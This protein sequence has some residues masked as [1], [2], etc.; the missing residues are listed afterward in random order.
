[1]RALL[2][3]HLLHAEQVLA[4]KLAAQPGVLFLTVAAEIQLP[5]A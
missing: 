1:M 3:D 4:Q 5:G 2:D